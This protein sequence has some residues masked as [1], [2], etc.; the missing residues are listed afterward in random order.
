M[1]ASDLPGEPSEADIARAAKH[2]TPPAPRTRM[3]GGGGPI[4]F[5]R[6]VSLEMGR[7]SW[8]SRSEVAST[9]VVVL[10][11]V[12]F[13]GLYLWGVDSLLTFLFS[14]MERWLQ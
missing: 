14:T 9:T 5:F 2:T 1:S 7:V 13:F 12:A 11:A 4:D 8:P 3:G 10:I 6:E